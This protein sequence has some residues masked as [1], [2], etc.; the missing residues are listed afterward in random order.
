MEPASNLHS[1]LVINVSESKSSAVAMGKLLYAL[2][3]NDSYREAIGDG[4]DTWQSY[5]GQPEIGLSVGEANRLIQIYEVFVIDKGYPESEVAE[6]P[7]KNLHRLLP[8]AKAGEEINELF[9]DAKVLSQ[10]DFREKLQDFKDDSGVRTYEYVLM[11]KC[12]ETGTMRKVHDIP[13]N[14]LKEIAT[15]YGEI[16]I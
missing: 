3:E 13:S 12:I 11:R 2:K 16:A 9:E 4:I 14:E 10:R 6:V 8:V 5:L 7:I 1:Y 15:I